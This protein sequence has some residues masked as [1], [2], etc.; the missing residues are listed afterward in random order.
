MLRISLLKTSNRGFSL[1]ELMI[2]ISIIAAVIAIAIPKITN[3]NNQ[4]RATLRE[5]VTLTREL[6]TQAKLKGKT[7][8]LVFQLKSDDPTKANLAQGYYVESSTGSVLLMNSDD[9]KV[10]REK[11]RRDAKDEKQANRDPYGFSSDNSV[12]KK[13]KILPNGLE[14]ES[15]E[16]KRAKTPLT[17]GNIGIH[18]FPQGLSEEAI[19]HFKT[20]DQ[21]WSLIIDP[22]LGKAAIVGRRVNLKDLGAQ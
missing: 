15:I 17:R 11:M 14:V 18:F 5:L 4:I 8:R 20:K 2:V 3:P 21:E 16:V 12:L 7:F 19:V 6:H 1:L 22:M 9:E 10:I 13:P